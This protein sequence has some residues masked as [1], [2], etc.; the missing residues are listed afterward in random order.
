MIV[1]IKNILKVLV[2]DSTSVIHNKH[3]EFVETILFQ[4]LHLSPV[5]RSKIGVMITE[6]LNME[7]I[8][9]DVLTEG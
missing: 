3:K 2:H 1:I 5:G 6:L 8:S 7:I 9:L 4:G